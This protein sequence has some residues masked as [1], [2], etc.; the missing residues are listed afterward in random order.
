[1]DCEELEKSYQELAKT[2]SKFI[3]KFLEASKYEWKEEMC[4]DDPQEDNKHKK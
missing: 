2:K 3:Y 1:M 4:L